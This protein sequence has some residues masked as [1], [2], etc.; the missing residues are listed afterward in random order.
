M[1]GASLSPWTT[2]SLCI[3]TAVSCPS[4]AGI[5]A[6]SS[7]GKLNSACSQSPGR[8]CPPFS[9]DPSSRINPGQPTPMNGARRNPCRPA[10]LIMARSM[11]A[12]RST[13]ASRLGWSSAWRHSSDARTLLRDRSAALRR[14][15]STRPTRM[16]EPPMSTARMLSWPANT[17]D[18]ARWAQP[19]SPASSGSCRIG[20]SR[21]SCPAAFRITAVRPIAS[22]PTRPARKPPPTTMRC[23]PCHSLRRR[24]RRIT[25]ANSWANSSMVPSSTPAASGSPSNSSRSSF[26]LLISLL[27]TSPSGSPSASRTRSRRSSSMARNARLLARSPMKPS[28]SRSSAL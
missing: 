21:T 4:M 5:A 10:C 19:S 2:A 9:I 7:R 17:Q 22:S 23:V 12:R 28:A 14:F 8:F 13:A 15:T 6:R 25:A 18:G 26:F 27:G 1:K 16:F 3:S 20:R 24:K 11:S